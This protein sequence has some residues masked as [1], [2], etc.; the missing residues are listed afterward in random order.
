[1]DDLV[2]RARDL[3][4]VDPLASWATRFVDD[5]RIYLDGNSLGRLPRSTPQRIAAVVEEWATQAVTAWDHWIDVGTRIGD[6]L[7]AIIGAGMGEV[8][9][10]DQTSVN[11]YKLASAAMAATDR[12]DIVSDRGNFPSDLYVLGAVARAGGG[13][14][15]VLDEDP[16]V[17]D[18]R[19]AVGPTV[20]LAS[21]SHVG[22]RSGRLLDA[23]AITD[24]AHAG[25]AMILWDLAHSVGVVPIELGSWEVDLAVGCTYKYLNGGP[26]SPGFLYVRSDHIDH[27]EQP[28]PGWF[29]HED[30]FGF[31][32]EFVPAASI[33]RFLVGT[34]PIISMAATREGIAMTR[35]AGIEAIRAKSLALGQLFI[36]TVDRF[37]GDVGAEV[38]TPRNPEER[39][40]HVA[41]RHRDAMWV[42][43]AL[44]REDVIPDFRSPDIIRFGFAPLYTSHVEVVSA[45]G[46]LERL[47][48]DGRQAPEPAVRRGV[49]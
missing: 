30:Q 17:A 26:G 21:F 4:D 13:E 41:I 48:R 33:R 15:V 44:R 36:E 37:A 29:G 8:A 18:V 25:G 38:V 1:V 10:C 43:M 6:E 24:A 39:G 34:P 32:P 27:L 2:G 11:L 22:Y 31:A 45:A 5:D 14:L 3:D 23:A 35:E 20:G 47:L 16:T 40:S 12:V 7:S 28:I 49:T 9:V 42:S 19:S 46:V